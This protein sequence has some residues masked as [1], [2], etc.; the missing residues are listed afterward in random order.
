MSAPSTGLRITPT[1]KAR[2]ASRT[3]AASC[4]WPCRP[5]VVIAARTIRV[6]QRHD[7]VAEKAGLHDQLALRRAERE[8]RDRVDLRDETRRVRRLGGQRLRRLQLRERDGLDLLLRAP[9]GSAA[10]ARAWSAPEVIRLRGANAHEVLAGEAAQHVDDD[11]RSARF[12]NIQQ[13]LAD[14][15]VSPK[16]KEAKRE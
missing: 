16:R 2:A 14:A 9:A 12:D 1:A 13:C 5:R 6:R 15:S 11:D 10:A 4:G 8:T 7:R 3:A